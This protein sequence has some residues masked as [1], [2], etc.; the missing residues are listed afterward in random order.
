MLQLSDIPF[1]SHCSKLTKVVMSMLP[2][3]VLIKLY[4]SNQLL[5]SCSNDSILISTIHAVLRANMSP[6]TEYYT[7]KRKLHHV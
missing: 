4:S 6:P 1:L 2:Y 3:D 7:S 5:G